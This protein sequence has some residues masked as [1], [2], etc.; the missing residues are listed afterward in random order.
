MS[1]PFCT[2]FEL[3]SPPGPLEKTRCTCKSTHLPQENPSHPQQTHA[4]LHTNIY[5]YIYM[6]VCMYT[7]CIYFYDI[8]DI[9]IYIHYLYIYIYIYIYLCIY[10]Y[11]TL[12]QPF[13]C[14]LAGSWPWNCSVSRI[15]SGLGR[16]CRCRGEVSGHPGDG[17]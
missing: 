10:T 7:Y 3:A 12:T 16:V 5:I 8:A 9:Y 1:P 17:G 13:F 11:T 2:P 15:S 14:V 6:Y 4:Q